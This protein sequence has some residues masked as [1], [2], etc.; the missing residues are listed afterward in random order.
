MLALNKKSE[1][2]TRTIGSPVFQVEVNISRTNIDSLAEDKQGAMPLQVRKGWLTKKFDSN[3]IF[4]VELS[5]CLGRRG[6]GRGGTRKRSG[7]DGRLPAKQQRMDADVASFGASEEVEDDGVH[8]DGLLLTFD[9]LGILTVLLR[10]CRSSTLNTLYSGGTNKRRMILFLAGE[11]TP[12]PSTLPVRSSARLRSGT[13]SGGRNRYSPPPVSRS[14]N[15]L[16]RMNFKPANAKELQRLAPNA[17]QQQRMG[18]QCK[19]AFT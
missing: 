5:C 7:D 8:S 14:A 12:S 19:S 6:A 17:E 10:H 16:H 2:V 1:K 18:E 13:S 4:L 15:R 11:K 9:E 3:R